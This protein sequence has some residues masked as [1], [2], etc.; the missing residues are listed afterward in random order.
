MVHQRINII[1]ETD[2]SVLKE[3]LTFPTTKIVA[4]NRF[5]KAAMT[6]KLCLYE[7]GN[8]KH[9]V[10]NQS[11][12]NL[13]ERWGNSSYGVILS[14]N[15]PVDKNHLEAP[16]NAIIEKELDSPERREGFKKMASA[17]K[18]DG[19]LFV[20]QLTHAGRQTPY[21]LNKNPSSA[22]DV[23]LESA[24][25]KFMKFAKPVA[26]TIEQIK[27]EVVD[28]FAFAAEYCYNAGFDGVQVHGAHGYLLAQFLSPTTNKRTDKYGGSI[29]N[30]TRLYVEVYEAIR[31]RVPVET[32]F[33]VGVK[34]NSVEFQNEGLQTSDAAEAAKIIDKTGYDFIELSGGTYEKYGFD[35]QRDSTTRREAFFDVFSKSI[36]GEVKHAIV[37]LTGGFR[38]VSGMVESIQNNVTDGIGLGRPVASEPS[39]PKR[40][41]EDNVQTCAEDYLDN[42]D[43]TLSF[44]AS[45]TQMSQMAK[46]P[47]SECGGDH[48]KGIM[49]LSKQEV[50]EQY[51]ETVFD[52]LQNTVLKA[53]PDEPAHFMLHFDVEE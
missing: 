37:Y 13:Y 32:G 43:F 33:I 20:A 8:I 42:S 35:K 19:A 51:M 9:G 26:L 7:P 10:P 2:V 38:R 6:E 39:F 11:L 14:G 22:S 30:R 25:R 36:K 45:N 17:G 3:S 40:V 5:L 48:C 46:L 41:L 47:F 28:K 44:L 50:S 18:A 34:L 27:T 21:A 24:T 16:G 23:H 12:I 49:D 4:R 1:E 53:N 29:E 52:F 15:I 31:E